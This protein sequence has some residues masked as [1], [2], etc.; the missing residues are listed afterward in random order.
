MNMRD[1]AS[2]V[3]CRH[4]MALRTDEDS[5]K[6]HG[7]KNADL[8]PFVG[9]LR[10]QQGFKSICLGI[11]SRLK[12]L[13]ANQ[14]VF[15]RHEAARNGQT[16]FQELVTADLQSGEVQVCVRRLNSHKQV[17]GGNPIQ[18]SNFESHSADA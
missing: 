6:Q 17:L 8:D 2:M 14:V 3:E 4:C 18:S 5:V 10:P 12:V 15:S 9:R 16:R 7:T 13:S 1:S 11:Q